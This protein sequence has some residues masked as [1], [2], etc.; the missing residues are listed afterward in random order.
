[1]LV[2]NQKNE[3]S[4]K[5]FAL[6]VPFA[7][8]PTSGDLFGRTGREG[9]GVFRLSF[10]P[11]SALSYVISLMT[12]Q[13]ERQVLGY[14]LSFGFLEQE[15]RAVVNRV[16][17]EEPLSPADAD[18]FLQEVIEKWFQMECKKCDLVIPLDDVPFVVE[19]REGLCRNCGTPGTSSLDPTA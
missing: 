6:G 14:L 19:S 15:T 10:R 18:I 11:Y 12:T 3:F 16:L 5:A 1:L 2:R 4:L 13:S 9:G 17:R 8:I 7:F